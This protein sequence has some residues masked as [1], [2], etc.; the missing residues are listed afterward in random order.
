MVVVVVVVVM[1]V[2][3]ADDRLRVAGRVLSDEGVWRGCR[4]TYVRIVL[5]CD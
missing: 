5:C 2:G 3:G 1:M 4:Y